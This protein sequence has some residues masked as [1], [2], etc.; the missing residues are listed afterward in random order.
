MDGKARA[1]DVSGS[2]VNMVW[3]WEVSLLSL[4]VKPSPHSAV[5]FVAIV[6]TSF[7]LIV[8]Q[9]NVNTLLQ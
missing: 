3:G 5:C 6:F 4:Q 1:R 9:Y 8:L 7:P 2:T